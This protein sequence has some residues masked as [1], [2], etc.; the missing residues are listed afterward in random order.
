MSAHREEERS[1]GTSAMIT[2]APKGFEVYKEP[3]KDAEKPTTKNLTEGP[4]GPKKPPQINDSL[5][6]KMYIDGA[7]NRLGAGAGIVLKSSQ[8]AI[9]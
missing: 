6:C 4:E 8:G 7:K 2:L 3:T 9:F 5:V 1:E